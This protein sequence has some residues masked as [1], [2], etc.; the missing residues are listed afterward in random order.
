M[1][2]LIGKIIPLAMVNNIK[3]SHFPQVPRLGQTGYKG[4]PSRSRSSRMPDCS[5]AIDGADPQ[6]RAD[7]HNQ[8]MVRSLGHATTTGRGVRSGEVQGCAGAPPGTRPASGI[9]GQVTDLKYI[10]CYS[11]RGFAINSVNDRRL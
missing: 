3:S 2:G 6:R 1:I 8:R 7:N 10:S 5:R 11:R 9:P 4:A